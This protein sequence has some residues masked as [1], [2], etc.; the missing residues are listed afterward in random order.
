M[1]KLI[2]RHGKPDKHWGEGDEKEDSGGKREN[3][4]REKWDG[5]DEK[6]YKG[7]HHKNKYSE[8]W[9]DEN[10]EKD[11]SIGLMM[12]LVAC[13]ALAGGAMAIVICC[14]CQRKRVWVAAPPAPGTFVLGRPTTDAVNAGATVEKG[15]VPTAQGT[16]NTKTSG[17]ADLEHGAGN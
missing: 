12:G 11:V 10:N 8:G 2:G 15:Q 17:I 7:S 5:D 4:N 3:K 16:S 14:V 13:G 6:E 1:G 9:D